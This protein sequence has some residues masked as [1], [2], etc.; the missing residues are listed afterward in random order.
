MQLRGEKNGTICILEEE[1]KKGTVWIIEGGDMEQYAVWRKDKKIRAVC[2]LETW[3][4]M[5]FGGKKEKKK[6]REA[7]GKLEEKILNIF[8]LSIRYLA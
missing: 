2:I 8:C 3:N 1:K 6:K 4:S 5:Y 7:L